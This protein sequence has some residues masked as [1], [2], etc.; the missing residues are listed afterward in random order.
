MTRRESKHGIYEATT[1]ELGLMSATDKT[2][3]DGLVDVAEKYVHPT[4]DGN[5][6]LPANGTTNAGKVPTAS[7]TAGVYTLETPSNAGTFTAPQLARIAV[8]ITGG[9]VGQVLTVKADGTLEW[10]TKA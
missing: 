7:A 9:T 10:A 2:K 8:L 3:L 4:T 1:T 5:K 6:H